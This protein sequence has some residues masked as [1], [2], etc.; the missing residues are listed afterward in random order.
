MARSSSARGYPERSGL[1]LR[2][3][4]YALRRHAVRAKIVDR[5]IRPCDVLEHEYRDFSPLLHDTLESQNI[6]TSLYPSLFWSSKNRRIRPP[7]LTHSRAVQPQLERRIPAQTA[8]RNAITLASSPQVTRD[9]RRFSDPESIS[10]RASVDCRSGILGSRSY[11]WQYG[12]WGNRRW[13]WARTAGSA[14]N[15]FLAG[16]GT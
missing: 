5:I 12:R 16:S 11:A 9:R 1:E 8:R 6:T 14:G 10:C 4:T 15:Y 13:R 7:R 3:G 2:V